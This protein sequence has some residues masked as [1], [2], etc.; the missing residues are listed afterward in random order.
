MVN[1]TFCSRCGSSL[2]W[3]TRDAPDAVAIALG[4]LDDE[5]DAAPR[6]HIF[7]ADK[8]GWVTAEDGLPRF[9]TLEPQP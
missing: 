5:P 3:E 4:P 9:D 2:F 1:R 8:A 6:A 7:F